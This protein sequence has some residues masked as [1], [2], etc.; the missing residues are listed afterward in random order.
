MNLEE[1]QTEQARIAAAWRHAGAQDRRTYLS[2]AEAL[3]DS[4]KALP[5]TDAGTI[6]VEIEDLLNQMVDRM[7]NEHQRGRSF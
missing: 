1:I 7:S 5:D 4:V 6:E 2:Q 3:L